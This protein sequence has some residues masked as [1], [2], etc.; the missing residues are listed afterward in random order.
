MKEISECI[1]DIGRAN[2]SIFTTLDLTSGFWQMKLDP[3]SQ[4]LTAFTIPNRGQFHW[5]T[6]PMGLLGCPASFQR[7]MEQVLRGL[8]HILIYIDDVLIHTDTHEKHLEAL[9]Q[10][11]L[12]LHQHHLKINLDKCLF[13]DR[14]VSY[15]GFTLTP[16]GIKPGKAKLKSIEQA[17]PPNDVKGIRSFMGLCNFFRHH[18]PDFS[19]IAAPLFKL[20]RQDSGYHSGPLTK[21]AL[22]AFQILQN[23][24]TEQPTLAFPRPDQEYIL[25]TNAYLP[26]RDSP[27]GLCANLAQRNN[28]GQIQIISHA[29]R[30]LRENEKN[31]TRF[32]LETAAAAWGMDNFN[33]Y[34]KGSR[35]TLYRDF[36]PEATLGTTQLKTLNRLRNTM[37]DHDFRTRDRQKAD[38]PQALKRSQIKYGSEPDPAFNEVIHVDL[39]KADSTISDAS[40]STILSITDHTRTFTRLAVLADD[41][42]DSVATTIW[43]HWCQPYGNPVTIRSNEGKVWTSKLESRMNKLNKIGPKITCR[44]EKETFFPEIRQQWEKHRLDTSAKNFAQDWN[45]L[46]YSQAPNDA[47]LR[48]DDLNQADSDLDDIEDF[49]ETDP[50]PDG[51]MSEKPK[52][53]PCQRKQVRLCRHKL[54]T[55]AYPKTT[56]RKVWQ[57]PE[58]KLKQ[59]N[60][61]LEHEWLQLIQLEKEIEK[62]KNQLREA[63]TGDPD[64]DDL[65][66]DEEDE[67]LAGQNEHL[68]DEDLEWVNS[69]FNSLPSSMCYRQNSNQLELKSITAKDALTRARTV[70]TLPPKFNQNFNQNSTTISSRKNNTSYFSNTDFEGDSELG[71]YFSDNEEEDTEVGELGDYFS[72]NEEDD[73][74][75]YQHSK[76]EDNFWSHTI[77]LNSKEKLPLSQT[78]FSDWN[79][80][81]S[82]L[83]A[84]EE[85]E[86][87][88]I[89]HIAGFLEANQLGLSTWP[90]FIPLAPVFQ[91]SAAHS[92]LSGF[93]SQA[94]SSQEPTRIPISTISTSTKL[95]KNQT[96]PRRE[97]SPWPPKLWRSSRPPT[98]RSTT[99][100]TKPWTESRGVCEE[101]RNW[102]KG[103]PDQ[104]EQ[105]NTVKHWT[106]QALYW[107]ITNQNQSTSCQSTPPVTDDAGDE[108]QELETTDLQSPVQ[109]PEQK[110]PPNGSYETWLLP[111]FRSRQSPHLEQLCTSQ[112]GS[113]ALNASQV[114]THS[115]SPTYWNMSSVRSTARIKYWGRR[116]QK[117]CIRTPISRTRSRPK[118]KHPQRNSRMTQLC[119]WSQKPYPHTCWSSTARTL[120]RSHKK[121]NCPLGGSHFSKRRS[122]STSYRRQSENYN[123]CQRDN[124]KNDTQSE[125]NDVK[126]KSKE[127]L[128]TMIKIDEAKIIARDDEVKAIEKTVEKFRARK[129]K[130]I[131]KRIETKALITLPHPSATI[132]HISILTFTSFI[133]TLNIF[134]SIFSSLVAD[135]LDH[136]FQTFIIG[137]LSDCKLRHLSRQTAS[138]QADT[139]V[140]SLANT[141]SIRPFKIPGNWPEVPYKSRSQNPLVPSHLLSGRVRKSETKFHPNSFI[142][143]YLDSSR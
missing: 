48:I 45:L 23:Q 103:C 106:K 44:S 13:G 81:I 47:N 41:K 92:R 49:V 15:L 43:H 26:D 121:I 3:E 77:D 24:L 37:I 113:D 8:N 134:I 91:N 131:D 99:K 59:E 109:P 10:V 39:I 72:D 2:S 142:F 86:E 58:Y 56:K 101:S 97:T 29:S 53:G 107:E 22:T 60:Q 65:P 98:R 67:D 133:C 141:D 110:Q 69:I 93:S 40:A 55:R 116:S 31:Y 89:E 85:K 21:E 66:F 114:S 17:K 128:E 25:I 30:Q 54:Q 11:L 100:W 129:E 57:P 90:P 7:L 135:L 132:S 75:L 27:G 36:T 83:E 73:T 136:H 51:Y 1:G 108:T 28:L 82:S 20:T 76:S 102:Q 87:T 16:E 120:N 79:P 14:Q 117:F 12:R 123:R 5:I 52:P 124:S 78:A 34:L 95:K 112:Q 71:D 122:E 143:N 32:L 119:L 42:I 6:S 70:Q 9:E 63:E 111:H 68:E 126:V 94:F 118:T 96:S 88:Q 46:C 105:S 104:P 61:D 140:K 18:I 19:I 62:M 33:E 4:P 50:N 139:V 84:F 138:I 125:T 38:L 64:L 115:K 127:N 130:Q 80:V 74:E 137:D 35:F